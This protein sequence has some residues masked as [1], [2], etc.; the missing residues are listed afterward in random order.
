MMPHLTIDFARRHAIVP[1]A[2]VLLLIIASVW[3]M[4]SAAMMWIVGQNN[5]FA[6]NEFEAVDNHHAVPKRQAPTAPAPGAELAAKQS[7]AVMR[8]LTVPWQELLSIVE[9]YA[10]RDVALIGID[11]NPAQGQLRITAEAKD[12]DAMI[13]YL[14][15]LQRSTLLR[16]AVLNTHVVETTVPGTPIR[17]QITAVW[18]KP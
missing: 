8:E 3:L 17:F 7:Q 2:G 1:A 15:Y 12:A 14:K 5:E 10:G 11:Q 18:R 13:A 6:R 16:E 9:S 4:V